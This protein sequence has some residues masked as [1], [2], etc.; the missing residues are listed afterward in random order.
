MLGNDL[1]NEIGDFKVASV[2]YI[3]TSQNS[4]KLTSFLNSL[5]DY[6]M[7]LQPDEEEL[8]HIEYIYYCNQNFL[9]N[10]NVILILKEIIK[11]GDAAKHS[12]LFIFIS[13]ESEA[14]KGQLDFM[15]DEKYRVI[16]LNSLKLQED[17]SSH[18]EE[19][20]DSLHLIPPPVKNEKSEGENLAVINL[21]PAVNFNKSE[22][23]SAIGFSNER[24]IP[25]LREMKRII[26]KELKGA[27]SI[28]L[29]S[30]YSSRKCG[31]WNLD[32]C[33]QFALRL[34][35]V[36]YNEVEKTL[37]L[38]DKGSYVRDKYRGKQCEDLM[39]RR[40]SIIES[41]PARYRD[42]V[43]IILE[44]SAKNINNQQELKSSVAAIVS[45]MGNNKPKVKPKAVR[46]LILQ[47]VDMGIFR[48]T[49]KTG[50]PQVILIRRPDNF[51][52]CKFLELVNVIKNLPPPVSFVNVSNK[53]GG[54]QVLFGF[55]KFKDFVA[56]AAVEGW[57]KIEEIDDNVCLSLVEPQPN[58]QFLLKKALEEQKRLIENGGKLDDSIDVGGI[59][60]YC[61]TGQKSSKPSLHLPDNSRFKLLLDL[62]G[63]SF[64][65]ISAIGGSLQGFHRNFGYETFKDY[66][67][68]AERLGFIKIDR[69]SGIEWKISKSRLNPPQVKF[70]S[71]QVISNE[72]VL[73]YKFKPFFDF[74]K[75]NYA[76]QEFDYLTIKDFVGELVKDGRFES[77][78]EFFT[79]SEKQGLIKICSGEINNFESTDFKFKIATKHHLPPLPS[80]EKYEDDS[81][82]DM[83]NKNLRC[84]EEV[85]FDAEEE[86]NI[87]DNSIETATVSSCGQ[88]S[89]SLS[90]HFEEVSKFVQ[91]SW[92]ASL[93]LSF[94]STLGSIGTI[95]N[96][97]FGSGTEKKRV[98][99]KG[100]WDS[101]KDFAELFDNGNGYYCNNIY[102]KKGVYEYKNRPSKIGFGGEN[103]I[104]IVD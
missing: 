41:F 88:S 67:E 16:F 103:N 46:E 96:N 45:T 37:T 71:S 78:L 98:F 51:M 57:I 30:P 85:F 39:A 90:T 79:L 47:G 83:N 82:V 38:T 44:E 3:P 24:F 14:L 81:S 29:I 59:S 35:L 48:T 74:I 21:P 63:Y 9:I 92:K 76:R 66:L 43:S 15:I 99:C 54:S 68:E 94:E 93:N 49:N 104:L 61:Q 26:C 13:E 95:R 5:N 60:K 75:N 4:P 70:F 25:F 17:L 86:N 31:I 80:K 22:Q 65:P 102:L 23:S 77:N 53:I 19:F 58:F 42:I 52:P 73:D 87:S 20:S 97:G 100:S 1:H 72:E 7:G 101:W 40:V 62:I 50:I 84:Q 8:P 91:I 18:V 69:D 89:P 28:S 55:E 36:T 11:L 12:Q 56:A 2:F 10:D 27:I 32:S 6:L 33:I 34:K 64:C